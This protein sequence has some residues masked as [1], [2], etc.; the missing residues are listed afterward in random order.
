MKNSPLVYSL[1]I[2]LFLPLALLAQTNEIKFDLLPGNNGIYLGKINAITRDKHGAMW[3]CDQTNQCITRYDGSLLTSYISDPHNVNSLGGWYPECLLADTTDLVWI[4]FYGQGLDKFN[5]K[6]NSFTHY[7][8]I[9]E[10]S[11]SLANDTITSLLIDHLG[12]FW[13]GTYAGLDLF[14][15]KTGIFTHF[16]HK[17]DDPTSLSHNRIRAVYE[18]HEGTLWIGT[19]LAWDLNE[20]GGLNRFDRENKS[21]TRFM[22]DPANPHSLVDNKVRAIFEDSRGNFWIGTR[23][24][25]LHRMDRK[26]GMFERYPSD[27]PDMTKPYRSP[28]SGNYDHITFITEDAEG[29]LWIGTLT[30]GV[31]RYDPAT[32]TNTFF[33]AKTNT[34]SGFN[35]NSGWCAHA[36]SD[37]LLWISTQEASLFKVELYQ[38]YIQHITMEG[39]SVSDVMVD[40]TNLFWL[41]TSHG[42]ILAKRNI[43][44]TEQ[45][46]YNAQDQN[47]LSSDYTNQLLRDKDGIIWISS[48]NGL[49]RFDPAVRSFRRFYNDPK[50]DESLSYNATSMMCEDQDF[51]LWVGTYGGGINR[52]DRKTEKFIRYKHI[53]ADTLSLNDDVV[54][55]VIPD[56]SGDLWIG[57]VEGGGVNRM[58]TKTGKCKRY[59]AGIDVIDLFRDAEGV[60]W[61]GAVQGLF[62]YDR[63]KDQF[64]FPASLNEVNNITNISSF[65]E[66]NNHNL[67]IGAKDGIFRLDA[68]RKNVVRFGRTNGI[69]GSTLSTGCA[70]NSHDGRLYFGTYAGYYAFYPD[71][72]KIPSSSLEVQL[73]NL[74]LNGKIV[75]PG[76]KSPIQQP[77]E[78]TKE[79]HFNYNQN[80]F[81]IG[82]S[83]INFGDPENKVIYYKLEGY[84]NEWH[85]AGV[86]GQALYYSVS[87]GKYKFMLKASDLNREKWATRS[88]DIIITPP[89]WSTW[90]AYIVYGLLFITLALFGYRFQKRIWLKAEHERTKDRELAQAKEVE[91]AYNEL[92]TTQAQLIQSEKMASLGELTAGIA[93]EIQN[94]LNFINNFSEVNAEL[95]DEMHEELKSGKPE[96]ALKVADNIKENNKKITHHGKRADAIVKGM[97]QHSRN[98]SGVKEP[99]DINALADEYL[100][101][102]YHGL[103]AKDKTFNAKMK[104]DFD[105]TIGM[106][107]IAPQDIGR[108]I[109]NLI[110]N[111]FYVVAEK[112]KEQSTGYEPT[113]TVSTKKINDKVEICVADNGNGIPE[114]VLD[115]IFQP[116]F[117]T[118]PSG[119]GTGLG[120]SMSYDI[121][122]AHGGELKVDTKE[123]EGTEFIIQLPM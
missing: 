75:D 48:A 119:Q 116:F 37:G 38:N 103:R 40:D 12:K 96:E 101:L 111:A 7:T 90:W 5:P 1:V 21:F 114:R 54:L 104:M 14:D 39:L 118:K 53:E 122:K 16:S 15:P 99:T 35:D 112:K 86:E 45:Y 55:C 74:W 56:D 30:G 91:K 108:V 31:S 23:G 120:L 32:H 49:T 60:F 34:S 85:H 42:L 27:H 106:M 41:A 73:T 29:A 89:W 46:V 109:L 43:G 84:D 110:T 61:L 10:D 117:T 11:R 69:I 50:N 64:L 25:G 93:H 3:F 18:D 82:F 105:E 22:H 20:E 70:V 113:V 33:N 19:G 79:I 78:T 51:N 4:G 71:K 8:H 72:L 44:I 66:D 52:F 97:L 57:T 47:S 67:W 36:S 81:S 94:P 123:G 68:S 24:D 87:P 2:L 77:M 121:V 100:R 63:A 98:S 65:T 28:V 17:A 83:M 9:A 92:K 6:N 26:T 59:L 13:I 88:V 58:N 62:R 95:I 80:A 102:A 76:E 115:K 107:N